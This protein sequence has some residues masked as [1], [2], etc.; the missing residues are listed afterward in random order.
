ME[1]KNLS[2]KFYFDSYLNIGDRL[3]SDTT[4]QS[5]DATFNPA[6][7]CADSSLTTNYQTGPLMQVS[8]RGSVSNFPNGFHKRHGAKGEI[9]THGT[10]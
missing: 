8:R 9:R 5:L 3:Y 6:G 4:Y 10:R 2:K 7:S 1:Y